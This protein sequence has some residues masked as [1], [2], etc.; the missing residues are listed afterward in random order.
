MLSLVLAV[1]DTPDLEAITKREP[2][3]VEDP[4]LTGASVVEPLIAI[5]GPKV[6]LIGLSGKA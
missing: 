5:S 6:S 3:R 1:A 4:P 2:E